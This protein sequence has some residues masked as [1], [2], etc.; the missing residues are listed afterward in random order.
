MKIAIVIVIV[1]VIV[2][3]TLVFRP[4]S[5]SP[6]TEATMTPITVPTSKPQTPFTATFEIYTNGTKRVFSDSRYHNLSEEVFLTA[7]DPSVVNVN[8][9]GITWNDFFA[10]LPMELTKDCLVTGTKQTFCSN[11]QSQLRFYIN[12]EQD[13]DALDKEIMAGDY[14]RVEYGI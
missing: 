6:V 3:A 13:P 9:P 4:T 7:E 8:N 1:A 12:D 11:D 5:T 10:T 14:L 2:A